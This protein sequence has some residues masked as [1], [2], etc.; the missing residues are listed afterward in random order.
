MPETYSTCG[1]E[2]QYGERPAGGLG[3]AGPENFTGRADFSVD[4]Y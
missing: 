2:A 3:F 4:E 1:A